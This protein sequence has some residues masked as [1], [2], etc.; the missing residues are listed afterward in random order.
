MYIRL[1]RIKYKR[2]SIELHWNER[3]GMLLCSEFVEKF[4]LNAP[5]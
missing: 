3:V 2:N 4:I 5:I 1:Y